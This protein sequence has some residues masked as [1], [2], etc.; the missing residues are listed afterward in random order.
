MKK[1]SNKFYG[2][3]IDL[4][5]DNDIYSN[6]LEKDLEDK[7]LDKGCYHFNGNLYTMEASLTDIYDF[8]KELKSIDYVRNNIKEFKIFNIS[9][10]ND[11]M[12]LI[13]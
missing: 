9:N 11:L 1:K 3:I 6:F 4:D 7:L 8:I 12:P 13:K 5:N 10:V 2:L